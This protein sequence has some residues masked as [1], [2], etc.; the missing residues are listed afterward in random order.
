MIC[1]CCDLFLLVA[2]RCL[3]FYDIGG[4]RAFRT[5]KHTRNLPFAHTSPA[6]HAIFRFPERTHKFPSSLVVVVAA[7][8]TNFHHIEN[9]TPL[10]P[11]PLAF[12]ST[13]FPAGPT[14]RDVILMRLFHIKRGKQI[15]RFG[16]IF[17]RLKTSLESTSCLIAL[18]RNEISSLENQTKK[19]LK[20]IFPH[21]KSGKFDENYPIIS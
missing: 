11:S 2:L 17:L 4:M 3:N 9:N 18:L 8:G 14:V 15:F 16:R 5:H 13:D 12:P 20:Q 6:S 21:K 1:G 7:S 10:A 19:K